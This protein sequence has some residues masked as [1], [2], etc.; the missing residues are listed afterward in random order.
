MCDADIAY[1]LAR[2]SKG[3][4]YLEKVPVKVRTGQYTE[5]VKIVEVERYIPPNFNSG[6][7]WLSNRQ[8]G[9]WKLKQAEEET[10]ANINIKISGGLP[11]E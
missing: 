11:D 10:N 4:T 1:S 5:D 3:I 9:K 6:Q 2:A 7:L 8:R